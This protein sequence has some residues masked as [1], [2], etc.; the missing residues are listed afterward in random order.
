MKKSFTSKVKKNENYQDDYPLIY[1]YD[2]E[3]PNEP[4]VEKIVTLRETV[5]TLIT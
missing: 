1:M 5:D 3:K 2:K 4:T